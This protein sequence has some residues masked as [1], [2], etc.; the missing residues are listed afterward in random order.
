MSHLVQELLQFAKS[1]HQPN[2]QLTDVVLEPLIQTVIDREAS[3]YDET[4]LHVN[5]PNDLIVRADPILLARA[6]GNILRNALRYAADS[7]PVEI[8]AIL[9]DNKQIQITIADH[10]PGVPEESLPKLF[11]AFYRPDQAR[12]SEKGGTG[13]GLAIVKFCIEACEGSVSATLRQPHGLE[14]HILLQGA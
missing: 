13:L 12:T 11:D 4:T 7:G 2:H 6:T 1:A 10:G 14:M 8:S 3:H 5:V 9:L